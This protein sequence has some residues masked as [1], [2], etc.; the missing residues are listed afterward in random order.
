MNIDAPDLKDLLIDWAEE[1]G[2]DTSKSY[3]SPHYFN[4]VVMIAGESEFCVDIER[5]QVLAARSQWFSLPPASSPEYF[6][7]LKSLID[8][9]LSWLQSHQT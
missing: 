8:N 3:D 5:N 1:Q 4:H 7:T 2:Y 6:T 9:W